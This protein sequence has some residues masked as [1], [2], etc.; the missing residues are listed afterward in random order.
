MI[1]TKKIIIPI[2]SRNITHYKS[3]GYKVTF[4]ENIEV[5]IDD[6]LS[7]SKLKIEA[8]CDIC[9]RC[10]NIQFHCYIENTNRGNGI[11]SC[12]H[13]CSKIKREQ[14]CLQKYGDKKYTKSLDFI[15]KNKKTLKEK[16][17]VNHIS[18]IKG[19]Q[20]KIKKTKK[21]KYGDENFNNRKKAKDT[22]LNKYGQDFQKTKEYKDKCKKTSIKK[23]G[24]ENCLLN[25]EI[26]KKQLQT[27]LKLYGDEYPIKTKKI[28]DKLKKTMN[29][30]YGVDF[31][32]QIPGSNEKRKKTCL[33][34]YGFENPMQNQEIHIKQSKS[35][36]KI[37][38]YRELYYRGSYELDFLI[39]CE[40]NLIIVE[41]GKTLSY[42]Y[43]N[44]NKNYF[45]DFY[46]PKYN[47]I[48]EIKST[49]TYNKYKSLNLAKKRACLKN[50][51]NFIFIIDKNYN[52]LLNLINFS[53]DL[54]K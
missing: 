21:E 3:K 23:F 52:K 32:S 44:K 22:I 28:Q 35:G 13:P 33:L 1:K 25:P 49:Y 29:E 43:K 2:N 37:K 30:K 36:F 16:Y 54:Y 53:S 24:Y 5:N 48:V 11:Y 6:L 17:G 18:E 7:N 47:L 10:N 15:N 4:G 9:G 26:R 38:Y 45:Y 8:I 46:L 27:N 41:Q 50:S 40:K 39:F 20:E 12:N 19:I 14:T 31:P 42:V 51:F 34:K